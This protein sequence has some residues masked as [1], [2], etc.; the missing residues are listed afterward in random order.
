MSKIYCKA[1]HLAVGSPA[2]GGKLSLQATRANR[3]VLEV[4]PEG[5]KATSPANKRA[6]LIPY[7]NIVDCELVYEPELKAE[8]EV[9]P[10]SKPKPVSM[11]KASV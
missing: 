11:M 6:I 3:N 8:S 2:L 1:V 9:E 4:T 7:S 10:K 5:I